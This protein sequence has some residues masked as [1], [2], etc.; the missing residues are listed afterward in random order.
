MNETVMNLLTTKEA[1]K[2]FGVTPLTIY[3]WRL[4]KDLPFIRLS[5][6]ERDAI[7]FALKDLK[8]WARK[9]KRGLDVT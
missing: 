9:H 2:R 7:R 3:K 5:G 1:A 6:V 4:H 8:E